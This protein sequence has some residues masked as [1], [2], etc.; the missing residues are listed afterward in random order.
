LEQE[1]FKYR[2]REEAGVPLNSNDYFKLN[3]L[4]MLRQEY[5]RKSDWPT[6]FSSGV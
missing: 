3:I 1:E 6:L 2:L 5:N 4:R